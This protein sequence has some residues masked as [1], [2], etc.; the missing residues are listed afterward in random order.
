[1]LPCSQMGVKSVLT[2]N[3]LVL[4]PAADFGSSG[5]CGIGKAEPSSGKASASGQAASCPAVLLLPTSP[6]AMGSVEQG[7]LRDPSPGSLSCAAVPRMGHLLPETLTQPGNIAHLRSSREQSRTS[8]GWRKPPQ[9]ARAFLGRGACT[10][11]VCHNTAPHH[12]SDRSHISAARL[13]HRL[14]VWRFCASITPTNKA[15]AGKR[16]LKV[17]RQKRP[18]SQNPAARVLGRAE[19]PATALP[20]LGDENKPKH[21]QRA[22]L[23]SEGHKR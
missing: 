16:R 15:E 5:P 18:Q 17:C 11:Q 23:F 2:S 1:M 6:W 22:R 9:A 8:R 3:K 21:T 20:Q 12:N 10:H 13:G 19:P 14:S 7:R 4:A